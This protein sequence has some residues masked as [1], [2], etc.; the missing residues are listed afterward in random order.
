MF[1]ISLWDPR[2]YFG[3]HLCKTFAVTLNKEPASPSLIS[4]LNP[5]LSVS[6][7]ATSVWLTWS[8]CCR[9]TTTRRRR[10][11]RWW[12]S[13]LTGWSRSPRTAAGLW[14]APGPRLWQRPPAD[15]RRC[16]SVER[17]GYV[18]PQ[19]RWER[20]QGRRIRHPERRPGLRTLTRS[21]QMTSTTAQPHRMMTH[22]Q[23]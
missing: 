5:A 21:R 19:R 20:W 11:L 13:T 15:G 1:L 6:S 8:L 2:S 16:F 10:K 7:R 22:H 23:P 3:M 18:G 14:R 9:I 4:S 12:W 17:R